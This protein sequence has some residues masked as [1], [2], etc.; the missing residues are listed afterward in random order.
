[1]I[2]SVSNTSRTKV[3]PAHVLYVADGAALLAT[4]LLA[5]MSSRML[6]R[7]VTKNR[8]KP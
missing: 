5:Y 3:F 2:R 7:K 1:M 4:L 8:G 6:T